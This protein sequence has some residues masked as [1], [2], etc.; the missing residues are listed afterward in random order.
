[1]IRFSWVLL[2]VFSLSLISCGDSSFLMTLSDSENALVIKTSIDNGVILDPDSGES[3]GISLEYD[4]TVVVPARLEIAFLDQQGLQIGNSQVIEGDSLNKQLPSVSLASPSESQY[5]V[6]LR[7]F[8]NDDTMIK[9]EIVSFFYSRENLAIRGLT[10]YPNVFLPGGQGLIFIDADGS[11]STWVRWSIDNEIIEEGYFEK[12][13]EGF[14]W[15]APM[16]E[17][18]YGLRMELFP[19]EPMYSKNG[20]F[21]FTS[22][23]RSELEVFV[24]ASMGES[25]LM[26]LQPA[27]SYSTNIHFK[28]LVVDEGTN[29]NKITTIGFPVIKKVDDKL[30]YYLK[31]GSGYSIEDNIL[32]VINNKLLP[33]SITFS[34]LIEELQE[35]VYFLNIIG[36]NSTLFSI[37][38]D[39]SGILYSELFQLEREIIS[40]SDIYPEKYHEITLSVIPDNNSIT[41][42]WYGDGILISSDIY[43]NFVEIPE[44]NYKSFI[45]AGNGFEGLLDEFGV[46]YRDENGQSNID[47][48]IFLRRSKRDYNPEKIIAAYGFDGISYDE[49]NI[50]SSL[51]N[52]GNLNLDYKSSFQFLETDFKFSYLYIDL[53]FEEISEDTGI[54]ISFP[55]NPEIDDI[56]INLEDISQFEDIRNY[57]EI[58]INADNGLLSVLSRGESIAEAVLV[59]HTPAIFQIVNNSEKSTTKV[60][61]LLVRREEKRVVKDMQLNLKTEL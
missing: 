43:N 30:G 48:N 19:V 17:G 6:R 21:P 45:S 42:L 41:F 44:G 35:D 58:E 52:S 38:T 8:D 5:S 27:E 50:P 9:E 14:I 47:N 59:I 22:P 36:E 40:I 46:Y 39:S 60:A 51:L 1:M 11:D 4:E 15:Q 7:V 37:K 12:Y 26:D 25:D 18:V 2:L 24:T 33:F 49:N 32:P 23:L 28:G 54:Q 57:F 20:T 10:Q 3:I 53:D 56:Y 13:S 31:E 34:Y 16:L 55:D 61:S 29:L